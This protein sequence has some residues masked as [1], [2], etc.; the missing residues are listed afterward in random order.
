[1]KLH[2][3]PGDRDFD[4]LENLHEVAPCANALTLKRH[5]HVCLPH[6][7]NVVDAS[8]VPWVTAQQPSRPEIKPPKYAVF[9]QCCQRILRTGRIKAAT[10]PA[11]GRNY[12]LIKTNWGNEYGPRYSA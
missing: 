9:L 2:H 5:G 3:Q 1:M 4:R 12:P 6:L 11:E 10:G 8:G 7:W